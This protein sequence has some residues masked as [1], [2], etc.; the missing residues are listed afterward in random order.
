MDAHMGEVCQNHAKCKICRKGVPRKD[1]EPPS[2]HHCMLNNCRNCN[3]WEEPGHRLVVGKQLVVLQPNSFRCFVKGQDAFLRETD[4]FGEAEQVI[5]AE[6]EDELGIYATHGGM[7]DPATLRRE[8]A[9]QRADESA[10][11]GQEQKI[12]TIY[13]DFEVAEPTHEFTPWIL[14]F[15]QTATDENG[16]HRP[17]I[18]V[19]QVGETGQE[20]QFLG[21]E[22]AEQ[23]LTCFER[24][25]PNS[26][27]FR[28]S[29]LCFHNASR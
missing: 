22:C 9:Q 19:A 2:L 20:F 17:T 18:L 29:T 4:G 14:E 21:P 8:R 25:H 24:E 16:Y 28:G 10:A 12:K 27:L 13:L 11:E 15:F 6:R 26:K 23:F 3:S 1:L 7:E 5:Q